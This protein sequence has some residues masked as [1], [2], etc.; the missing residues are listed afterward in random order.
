MLV[1]VIADF[2]ED[3]SA[4]TLTD[5]AAFQSSDLVASLSDVATA[6]KCLGSKKTP[7]HQQ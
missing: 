1:T 7:K 2:S 3:A 4:L 5:V 6:I